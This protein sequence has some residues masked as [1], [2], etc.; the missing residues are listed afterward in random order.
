VRRGKGSFIFTN[1]VREERKRK[2][3]EISSRNGD[4]AE[5]RAAYVYIIFLALDDDASERK[6][7][8]QVSERA[9]ERASALAKLV[10]VRVPLTIRSLSLSAFVL[11]MNVEPALSARPASPFPPPSLSPPRAFSLHLSVTDWPSPSRPCPVLLSSLSLLPVLLCASLLSLYLSFLS[12]YSYLSSYLSPSFYFIS[13][14]LRSSAPALSVYRAKQ[15]WA[16]GRRRFVRCT[17]QRTAVDR[18][19][20]FFNQLFVPWTISF[21]RDSQG[22]EKCGASVNVYRTTRTTR[23]FY[24]F[25]TLVWYT[26]MRTCTSIYIYIFLIRLFILYD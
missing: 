21:P 5:R 11:W 24:W 1:S 19:P 10:I 2:E 16:F 26:Y 9:S 6:Q 4:R 12:P 13:V 23:V 17:K 18:G 15:S 25:Y 3:R 20:R 14:P 7:R 22:C 8:W